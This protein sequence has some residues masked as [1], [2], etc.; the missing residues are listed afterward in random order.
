MKS[1]FISFKDG[2]IKIK[3]RFNNAGFL[4]VYLCRLTDGHMKKMKMHIY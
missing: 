4:T 1:I 2:D 3:A